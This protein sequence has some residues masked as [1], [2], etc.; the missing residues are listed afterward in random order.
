MRIQNPVRHL[1]ELFAN[2]VNDFQPLE[3]VTRIRSSKLAVNK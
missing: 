2:L 3:E 1:M